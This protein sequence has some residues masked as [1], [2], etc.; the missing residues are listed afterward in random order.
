MDTAYRKIDVD[1]YD[2]DL[3]TEEELYTH[4]PRSAQEVLA[5]AQSKATQIDLEQVCMSKT[6]AR[7]L[8]M[9]T[10]SGDVASALKLLLTS[11]PYGPSSS[12]LDNA[13][14]L[15]LSS[16]IET[17]SSTRTS[18]IASIVQSFDQSEQDWLMKYLYKGMSSIGDSNSA[19][20]LNWHEKLTE[21][22]GTGCIVRVMTDRRRV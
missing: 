19:V 15:T 18:E 11:P 1:A 7:P 12:A 13:K 20:L 9:P 16:V 22:A 6:E 2:E 14:S 4:D 17:L 21:V 8:I 5:E 3:V 10:C